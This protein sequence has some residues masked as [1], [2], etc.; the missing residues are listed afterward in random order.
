[1]KAKA[2]V[3]HDHIQGV[4]RADIGWAIVSTDIFRIDAP[5]FTR[6][7]AILNAADDLLAALHSLVTDGECYCADNVLA[8][9]PCGYC[10]A[11]ELLKDL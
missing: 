5:E 11:K 1:M 6:R 8:K 9:A 4:R 7:A 2:I 3:T 10:V